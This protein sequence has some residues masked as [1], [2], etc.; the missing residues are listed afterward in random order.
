VGRAALRHSIGTKI[1][2]AFFAMSII[3]AGL[4]IYARSVLETSGVIVADT[5]DK[6][7]MAINF[8]RAASVDFLQMQNLALQSRYGAPDQRP[9]LAKRIDTLADTLSEDLE[10]AR[11]RSPAT[12]E[13]GTIAKIEAL[14]QQWQKTRHRALARKK[15]PELAKLNEEILGEF[16]MLVELN[17]DHGFISRREAVRRIENFGYVVLLVTGIAVLMTGFITL[18]LQRRISR[19]L[20]AAARVAERIAAGEFNTPIPRGGRDETGALLNSMTVMQTNI[21]AYIAGEKARAHSAESR[22]MDAIESSGEGVILSGPDGTI[23]ISSSEIARFFPDLVAETAAGRPMETALHHM[24]ALSEAEHDRDSQLTDLV[25]NRGAGELATTERQLADGRWLRFTASRTSDNGT[26]VFLSDFT[27]IKQREE[28]YRAAKLQAE[29][30]SAAK[31]RFLSNMS[32]ELRTPLN[33]IIGFSEIMAGQIL[34]TLS[35]RYLEYAQDIHRS[36]RHLLD[37][38]NSVL[39]LA[40]DGAGKLSLSAKPVDLQN[41]LADCIRMLAVQYE[42]ASVSFS[43]N[44][45]MAPLI[46]AGEEAKL[47]QIFVNLLSN[48]MKFTE[49]GGSVVVTP[50]CESGMIVVEIDDSGIGMSEDDI[51]VALTPFAQVDSRLERKYEGTGLGLPLAKS[52]IELHGGALKIKSAPKVGTTVFVSLPQAQM[53]AEPVAVAS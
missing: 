17:A 24:Q 28:R 15:F 5:Y 35:V 43:V 36:G 6:P 41:V 20:S 4:G 51:E 3:V 25:Q 11:Q 29:E 46:V 21:V 30:A 14:V 7:M 12:D 52:L 39:D 23:A 1:F 53:Q 26:I 33:A 42:A 9:A 31:T 48:A 44:G 2:A 8:A 49:P 32:H 27:D 10:V 22:L 16:D 37:V 34:G 45:T 50:R 18:F 19:P 40:K 38:I 13:R 47:R